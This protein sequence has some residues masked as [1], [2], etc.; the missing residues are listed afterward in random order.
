MFIPTLTL[1]NHTQ[2]RKATSKLSKSSSCCKVHGHY[3]DIK[4]LQ[5][6]PAF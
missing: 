1:N 4:I 6:F 3:T 5:L 2:S